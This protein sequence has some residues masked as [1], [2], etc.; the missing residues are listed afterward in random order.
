MLILDEVQTGVGRMGSF[1]A[2]EQSGIQPDIVTL[3]KGLGGGVPVSAT[4]AE[5][6]VCCF[7]HGDQG[8]TY[9]GNPLMTSVA[10][11]VVNAV[12]DTDFLAAVCEAG[13]T[14]ELALQQ[15]KLDPGLTDVRG[16]GLLWAIELPAPVASTVQTRAMESG[17]LVNAPRPATIRLMPALNVTKTEIADAMLV[18]QR[19]I[20][21]SL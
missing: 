5:A 3:G 13:K 9:N 17:L 7:E 20:Q 19:A 14:L 15:L 1:F 2:F 4:L 16:A 21:N 12:A 8:G 10:L 11:S 6:S 18:L